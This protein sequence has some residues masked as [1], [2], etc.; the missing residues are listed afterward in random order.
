MILNLNFFFFRSSVG[1]CSVKPYGRIRGE[2]SLEGNVDQ[3]DQ[4]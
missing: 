3:V 4:G 1:L 2:E